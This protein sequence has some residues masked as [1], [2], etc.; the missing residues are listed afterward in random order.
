MHNDP[1]QPVLE[2]A[3]GT[4]SPENGRSGRGAYAIAAAGFAL[5]TAIVLSL[6]NYASGLIEL[7]LSD[8][9]TSVTQGQ[10]PDGAPEAPGDGAGP[11]D[12]WDDAPTQ[13]AAVDAREALSLSLSAYGSLVD[14]TVSASD[15]AGSDTDVRQCVRDLIHA[16][17]DATSRLVA[18]LRAAARDES[19]AQEKLDEALALCE[20]TSNAIAT[21]RVP[22]KAGAAVSGFLSD[23]ISRTQTRWC[24]LREE[25]GLIAKGGDVWLDDLWAT[26]AQVWDSTDAAGTSL[27][28]ALAT[29]AQERGR[30]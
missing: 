16:D 9:G 14:Y 28:S 27:T 6:T 8:P 13:S 10:G 22:A 3:G 17:A 11:Q 21:I 15:Y 4:T 2:T 25:V 24:A 26:D 29:S 20:E 5:M 1:T 19:V 7:A 18:L 12:R 30:Q 23:G